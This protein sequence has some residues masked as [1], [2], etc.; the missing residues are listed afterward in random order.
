MKKW[1]MSVGCGDVDVNS[2][3]CG[4]QQQSTR[5]ATARRN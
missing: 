3:V 1:L 2:D 5:T 4:L